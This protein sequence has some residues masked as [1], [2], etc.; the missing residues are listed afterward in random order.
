MKDEILKKHVKGIYAFSHPVSPDI[1]REL[2]TAIFKAMDEYAQQL[3]D[4]Q[5]LNFW[6]WL[7]KDDTHDLVHDLR[8]VGEFPEDGVTKEH[9]KLLLARFKQEKQ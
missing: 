2:R 3:A 5:T 4:E 6:E 8:I 7:D 1:L 9:M